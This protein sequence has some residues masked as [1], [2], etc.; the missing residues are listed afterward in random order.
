MQQLSGLD[1]T[2][3]HAE[4]DGLPQHI[5]GISIY[6]P[7]TAPAGRVRFE[8]IRDM[9]R[10]RLHLSPIFTRR[11][12]QVPLRLGQPYWIEDP[13]FDLDRH[14]YHSAL[15]APGNW[16]QL[17][18]LT[19]R[20]HARPLSRDR[21]LWEMYIIEGLNAIDGVPEGSFA[22]L[23][24]VHHAAMDGATGPLF[25]NVMHDLSPQVQP[26]EPEDPGP[27]EEPSRLRMLGR[28]Y[29]DA[30]GLP[31]RTLRFL[32]GAL[33]SLRRVRRGL[34]QHDFEAPPSAPR[35]RFQGAISPDRVVNAVRFDFALARE[36][37]NSTPQA[38]IND[39]ML[40]VV[41]G[42]LQRYLEQ[43]DEVP[44]AS[45]TAVCPID[46]REEAERNS[47]GNLLSAMTVALCTEVADPLQRL[48][49]VGR[50]SREGKAYAQALGPRLGVDITDLVP[51]AVMAL[52]LRAATAMGL[53]ENTV[54]A[55][56]VVTNV[57]GP[58]F[59]LYLCG[60]ELV[61]GFSTGPL[62]PTMGLFHV[63]YSSVQHKQGT[64][65]LSV[66]ACP[67]ML[68]DDEAYMQCLRD[69]FD[70]LLAASR[71]ATAAATTGG[72]RR[73]SAAAGTKARPPA[74]RKA[75]KG[76]ASKGKAATGKATQGKVSRGG[77]TQGAAAKRRGRAGTA[78]K[79]GAPK[80]RR[81]DTGRKAPQ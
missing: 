5:G 65:T 48:R 12:A 36:I 20:L 32:R 57:P 10:R 81:D 43:H 2:F 24:K 31:L 63:V 45:L 50:H 72:R 23:L 25:M 15:P 35:T 41:G 53:A 52:A 40:T 13:D 51:G 78:R 47:G 80:A 4:I 30:L 79:R 74:Q 61:D 60:A 73:A 67:R 56:T 49:E 18:D 6:D 66:T 77:S 64:L 69:S 54:Y 42:A 1:A 9:L 58:P 76:T 28:A 26:V 46:V 34:R 11:L 62:M 7:S 8:D 37:K 75:S 33:P 14:L 19:G 71:S 55:N 59:Q 17:C 3:I 22:M 29:L 68:P 44:P 38:T 21:P 16:Q 70:E 39:V 27:G